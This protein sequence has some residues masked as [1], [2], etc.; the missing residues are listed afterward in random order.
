MEKLK[1]KLDADAFRDTQYISCLTQ[2]PK[3]VEID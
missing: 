1:I 3:I 2:T